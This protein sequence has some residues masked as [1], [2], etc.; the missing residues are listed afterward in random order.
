MECQTGELLAGTLGKPW[1]LTRLLRVAIGVSSSLGHLHRQGLLHSDVNPSHILVDRVSGNAWLAGSESESP[2]V[3]DRQAMEVPPMIGGTLPYM[4]PEQTGRM[5]RSIDSRSDLYSLG[6]T[7]YEMLTGALPFTASDP[8]EWI[9]CHIARHPVPASERA[10]GIPAVLSAIVSKLMS[11]NAED[12]YQT[13]HGLEEDLRKCLEEW[14]THGKIDLFTLGSHDTSARLL[15]PEKLHGRESEVSRLHAAFDRVVTS[16]RPEL[17]LVSGY[18]GIGKS[19]VVNELRKALVPARGLFASGKF[20]QYKRDIPYATLCQALRSLVLRFLGKSDTELANWRTLLQVAV[21]GH[22]QLIVNL[23]PEAELIIGRQPP[24]ADLAR[25]DSETRFRGVLR[26]FLGALAQQEHPLVLFLD[27]LQW[28]DSA[29]LVLLE[30]LLVEPGVQHLLLIGAY[31]DNE[32]DPTHPLVR[33]LKVFREAEIAMDEIVLAPLDL[34][35]TD[36]LVADTLNCTPERAGRLAGLI[37]EKTAG[38]P[39]FAMQFLNALAEENLILYM[40]E[41]AAWSWDL[42]RIRAKSHTDNVVDLMIAKLNRLSVT[43]R[44]VLKQ[45]ASL[46]SSAETTTLGMVHGVSVEEIHSA[47]WEAVNVGLVSRRDNSYAFLHDRIQE[48]AYALVPEDEQA[49]IHLR[50]GRL[51]TENTPVEKREENI[52]EIVNQLNRGVELITSPQERELV[53][54]LNLIAGKRAKTATAYSSSLVYVSTGM[55]LLGEDCWQR[56]YALMFAMELSRAECEFLIGETAAAEERLSTLAVHAIAL[57][58]RAAV[59]R[60]RVALYTTLDRSDRAIEVGL[61]YLQS[62]GIEWSPHPT[63]EEIRWECERMW[64]LLGNRPIEELIDLSLMN[65][66]DWRATM[67]V[68]VE[69]APPARFTGGNLHHLLLLRMTNLSLEH[70]NCDGSCYAYACLPIVLGH[71]FNDYQTGFRF[72]KLGVDLVDRRGLDRFKARVYMC[73]GLL[74]PWTKHAPSRRDW[75][76]RSFTTANGMGDLTFAA[77]S[78]KNLITNLLVSGVP[79]GEVQQE[80]EYGLTFSRKAQFGLVVDSFI[81][82]LALIRSLRGLTPDFVLNDE[83]EGNEIRFERY[84]AEKPHLSFPACCYWIHKLQ[85]L[86]FA[87]DHTGA[88]EA[89]LKAHDLLWA[90]KSFLE[91]AD[92]H[93]YAALTRAAAASDA[94][95]V[96]RR[97]EHIEALLNH[98][99]QLVIWAESCPENFANRASLVA[100]EIARLEHRE[101]DAMRLYE[102][103]I[104]LAREQS[105]IQNEGLAN[106]HAAWFCAGHG[107][108]ASSHAYLRNARQ[109]YLR[110]GADGKVKQLDRLHPHLREEPM[111]LGSTSTIGSPVEHLDLATVVRVSQAVSGEIVFERLIQTLMRI[112]VKHAGA[113]RALFILPQDDEQ[114]LEAEAITG[115]E[116]ITV[117][118]VGRTLISSDLPESVL[119]YVI[120][121]QETVILD[122]ALTPNLFSSDGYIAQKRARSILCISLVKQMNVVGVLYLENSTTSYT[123]TPDWV[124]VLKLLA[125]QAAISIE[126]ARFYKVRQESEDRLRLVIDTIPAMVWSNSAD[127]SVE[128]VNQR[129]LEYTG[130]IGDLA[131]GDGWLA[132]IHP[133]DIAGVVKI[134]D[135]G[136]ATSKPYQFEARIRRTDGEYRYFLVRVFPLRDETGK[137]VKWYGANTDIEDHRR[138]EEALQTAFEKIRELKDELHRENVALKEEIKQ[139]SMFEEIVGSSSALETVLSRASKVAPTDSTVLITGETG[140]GKELIAR[141]IHKASL[142]SERPFVSVNC[143]A[144]PQSLIA[145]ELFGHEKGAFTGAQQRRLGRFELADG[146]TI[147]LDE[148]GELPAETQVALLRVLQE[149]EFERV[150]GNRLIRTDVR[151]ITAT[152]RNLHDAIADGTFRSDLFYRLN[153]FPIEIPPLRGRKE[154]IPMLVQ[155]FIDRFAR[156]MGKKIRRIKKTTMDRLLSYP[157]PGNVRELQNVIERSLVIC[158]TDT[159]TVD[160]SWLEFCPVAISKSP[161]PWSQTSTTKLSERATI[162]A[163]LAETEG[164]VSGPRGAAARLNMPA[165]TLDYKIRNS[166][167]DKHRFKTR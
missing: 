150:G 152:N 54:G 47:L 77:Y 46:G 6:I 145:S 21:G 137:I 109:C 132:A 136:L 126:N 52:F 84:L 1:E 3:S 125:S 116:G 167:I 96:D 50:I 4:A 51:L 2:I 82:Q 101:L 157:W 93:F 9:H 75:M 53:A 71:R 119:K 108:Q 18:S 63:D 165:S 139:S 14:E 61:E 114:R 31:R 35:D 73:F 94:A 86:F 146:G 45:L 99:E 33:T 80:A 122:D 95:L 164:R 127:G 5:N 57:V 98:Y 44:D 26:R 72:G 117:R 78:T 123:F 156:K 148:V 34:G 106:E 121:A 88:V 12:R 27:D 68:L 155:S 118:F 17:V 113:E 74:M 138:A 40:P 20:D 76:R 24:I 58:D 89:A 105:F 64:H 131:L 42:E 22:G 38:N 11:K 25:N 36:R 13:A 142:R 60:L 55:V 124:G 140:T 8:I 15:I 79:L 153:V 92:Y 28:T 143:A 107:F 112:V 37:Y 160:E 158:E 70:G 16:G 163:V 97:Q 120:R 29:T 141:A 7:L 39:F 65:D 104:R 149:R 10:D 159:F 59:T 91:E 48:A 62:I 32:V 166:N 85:A 100:A 90:T 128:S 161:V 115:R 87:G 81:G 30:Y 154:D 56:H 135:E 147:F 67:D 102:D 130:L 41:I 129:W 134:R 111:V 23:I 133:D 162:E 83:E 110:W 103:A 66:P 69:I 19:S 144:I 151:V 49:P 43:T